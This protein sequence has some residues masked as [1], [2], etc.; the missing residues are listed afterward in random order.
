VYLLVF[1]GGMAIG[2]I[3]WG[4]VAETG[5]Y[6]LALAAATAG[7]LSSLALV[8]RYS[9]KQG[10][11]L[12]LK[13]AGKWPAPEIRPDTSADKAP[14]LVTVQYEIDRER[15]QEFISEM[16]RMETIR[17]RDGALQWGLFID[18]GGPGRYVEE[19][20]VE[21]WLEHMR[22]HE[23]F[24]LSDQEVQQRILALHKGAAAPRVTHYLA[25]EE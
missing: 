15:V 8:F 9:L 16:R 17:R 5:G 22:Q 19:F 2:S 3:G 24:T 1:Q 18:P 6:R 14:V 11:A 10:L 20:L 23:R 7:L 25:V 12:N 4:V 21:S 13:P